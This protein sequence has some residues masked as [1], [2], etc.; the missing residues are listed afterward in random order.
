MVRWGTISRAKLQIARQ[1]DNLRGQSRRI[2]RPEAKKRRPPQA[3]V[4]CYRRKLKCGRESPACSRCVKAG[5]G[6]EC[7]Y[8]GESRPDLAGRNAFPVP[9]VTT[10]E[11]NNILRVSEQTQL[12]SYAS[13][14]LRS[15]QTLHDERMTHLKG[16][17]TTTKFYGFSYHLNLYQQVKQL[18]VTNGV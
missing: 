15:T 18:L 17:G 7:T 12:S 8:R 13:P 6:Q 11:T 16:Q 3:C 2:V 9:P 14:H 4:Q 10:E 1:M 5:H